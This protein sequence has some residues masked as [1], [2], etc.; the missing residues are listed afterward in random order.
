MAGNLFII[1][2]RWSSSTYIFWGFRNWVQHF[3]LLSHNINNGDM[4]TQ[5]KI[6]SQYTN[7]LKVHIKRTLC[8]SKISSPEVHFSNFGEFVKF[9]NYFRG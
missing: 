9:Q 6:S 4:P 1:F 3:S 8:I 5:S 2:V 7:K